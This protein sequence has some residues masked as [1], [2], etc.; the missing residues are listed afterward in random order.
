VGDHRKYKRT[1]SDRKKRRDKLWETTKS[2]REQIQIGRK[3]VI[4]C[5][6]PQKVPENKFK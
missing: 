3:D 4:N 6:R 2:T 5:G 1:N